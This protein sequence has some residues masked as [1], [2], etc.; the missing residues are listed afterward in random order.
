MA[1]LTS[2]QNTINAEKQQFLDYKASVESQLAAKDQTIAD[3]QS[4]LANAIKPEDLD[5]IQTG[6]TEIVP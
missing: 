1:D 3:L 5:A 6:I 2:L 4:Q